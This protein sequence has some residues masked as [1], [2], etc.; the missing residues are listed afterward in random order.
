[1]Y[2]DVLTDLMNNNIQG[3]KY[4]LDLIGDYWINMLNRN[5]ISNNSSIPLWTKVNTISGNSKTGPYVWLQLKRKDSSQKAISIAIIAEIDPQ[6][7]KNKA[8]FRVALDIK[9]KNTNKSTFDKYHEHFKWKLTKGLEYAVNILNQRVRTIPTKLSCWNN[10]QLKQTIQ[11][12]QSNKT[13]M[14]VTLK[15]IQDTLYPQKSNGLLRI[16]ISKYIE[17]KKTNG[18]DLETYYKHEI[19]KSIKKIFPYYK[20]VCL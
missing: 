5:F 18:E 17:N 1:M 11:N 9:E 6:I 20:G 13:N 10:N 7:D 12:Y 2:N 3:A 14:N 19:K 16:N 4:N 15:D 8:Y